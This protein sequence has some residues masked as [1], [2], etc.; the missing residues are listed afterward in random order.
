MYSSASLIAIVL[1]VASATHT[2]S[3]TEVFSYLSTISSD[4]QGPLD[5]KAEL[6][7]DTAFH[8]A[9][10]AV[11]MH[12]YTPA[13]LNFER[14]RPNAQRLRDAGFFAIS[15]A[16]RGRDGS[17]GIRDS[18]G[19]EI[20]DIYDAVEAVKAAFPALVD[21]TNVHITGYSG[22]GGNVMSALTRFPDYFRVGSSFYGMSD[23][24]YDP[25][26]GWY[27]NGAGSRTVTLDADIGVPGSSDNVTDKYHARASNLASLNNPYSEIHLFVN[28]NET[29]CPPINSTSYRANA[30]ANESIPGE[31]NNISVH[32]GHRGTYEDF[33]NNQIDEPDEEQYW[34][35]GD[36]SADR[37]YAGE[38]WYLDRLL[39][40]QIPEPEL[41]DSDELF[42]AGFVKTRPFECWLGDRQNAAAR[43]LY[44]V[45]VTKKTFAL[46]ILSISK[47]VTGGLRIDT[48]DMAGHNVVVRLNDSAVDS[49]L[50]GGVYQFDSIGHLDI[51]V[52]AVDCNHNGVA[53]GL[54][55]SEGTSE[56]C[57]INDIPDECE[58]DTDRDGAIDD[59]DEDDD[60]D[61][62]LD[63]DDNCPLH[64]NP[65][66]EDDDAD[67]VGNPCDLCLD[68]LP[69]A[70]VDET[71][72]QVP[73]PSDS[74]DDGD[75]DLTDFVGFQGCFN[76]PNR[77]PA[78]ACVMAA[79]FDNDGDVDLADFSTF[80]ACFN[81]VNRS[82][83]CVP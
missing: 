5:L 58:S 79:D 77:A 41:K 56:D 35:H 14:V 32:I 23:Y 21:P 66:Q 27:F 36:L 19:I 48:A 12:G 74:D 83:A 37:Q 50:G 80:A 70:V 54:D 71:G 73:I 25:V 8:D 3:R 9:P 62:L 45:S 38:A 11:V 64:E 6:N 57:N 42:V 81:G 61:G 10:I 44:S 2:T 47:L 16:M 20:Y 26:N 18:G 24:G 30:V 63:T 33:N 49:F 17:D 29:I 59:C 13:T 55:I 7:Y 69:G 22:G 4:A 65:L 51:L 15:V 72:C 28:D 67:Q 60:G 34:P 68:S 52:F 40:G 82:P 46:E 39:S 43:L 53:D 78:A 1:C 75:V 31:F 76:G